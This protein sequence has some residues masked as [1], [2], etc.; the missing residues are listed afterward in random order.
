MIV[1]IDGPA[2]SGKSTTA[3]GVAKVLGFDYLDTGALYRAIT[4]A[5]VEE[6]LAAKGDSAMVAF[7]EDLHIR[8]RFYKGEVK[9]L[10][11]DRDVTD[12][13]RS[14]EIASQV[15]A[16]SAVGVVRERM[17]ELQRKFA[18]GKNLVAEGRDMGSVVFPEAEL[19][20]FLKSD[21][22]IRAERRAAEFAAQG[23]DQEAEKVLKDLKRRDS[24][25]SGREISPLIQTEDAQVLDNTHMS[26]PEQIDAVVKLASERMP[27]PAVN[28][29]EILFR[30]EM[31]PED[32]RLTS[33]VRPI[34]R[35]VW[36]LV[37]L[38][39]K[40]LFGIRM[41]HWDRSPKEGGLLVASNHV[42]W[43][44]PP[45]AGLAV[46]RELTF[47]AKKEL[48]RNRLF[49]GLITYFN[50]VP[51]KRGSFDRTC[52]DTLGERLRGGGTVFFFPEGTRKPLGRLGKA[53]WGLGLMAAESRC[54]VQPVFIKGTKHWK[55]ALIR[56]KRVELYLGRPLHVQ[57]LID[58]GLEGRE[59]YEVFGEGVM[60]EIARL[61]EEAGGPF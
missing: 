20:I 27:R 32:Y 39:G 61:Q 46:K 56:R 44:D 50:A 1:A 21:P 14:P 52:F 53:K 38:L 10:I 58:R 37:W 17:V 4:L 25:D 18:R 11:G 24:L 3:K 15:S 49:G 33:S 19:K 16:F 6:G 29:D 26:I 59:L 22:I 40:L 55:Q 7:L 45:M 48:F 47:V 60:A 9:V 5:A 57:P 41:H 35:F 31:L 30:P 42:A 54:P 51:I 23:K 43:L 13:I 28:P 8:Y 2:A 12:E 36:R 34:Y